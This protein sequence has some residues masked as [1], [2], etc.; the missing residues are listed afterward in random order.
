MDG[1]RN[2]KFKHGCQPL[3]PGLFQAG[4]NALGIMV[5]LA[6]A[7]DSCVLGLGQDLGLG[8]SPSF[9]S[10]PGSHPFPGF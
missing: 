2:T 3:I 5:L 1:M 4:W 10:T 7:L 8:C 6:P 9:C